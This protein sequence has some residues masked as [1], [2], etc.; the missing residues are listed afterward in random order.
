MMVAAVLIATVT[1]SAMI[2]PPGGLMAPTSTQTEGVNVTDKDNT[3]VTKP[4]DSFGGHSVMFVE[5]HGAAAITIMVLLYAAFTL[6]ICSLM[7]SLAALEV[8]NQ[9]T[10]MGFLCRARCCLS[11]WRATYMLANVTLVCAMLCVYGAFVAAASISF[12]AVGQ[13]TSPTGTWAACTAVSGF[14]VG[15]CAAWLMLG[16]FSVSRCVIRAWQKD[17]L[18][19]KK[20]DTFPEE[21]EGYGEADAEWNCCYCCYGSRQL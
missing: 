11:D 15:L 21:Q 8:P 12:N 7:L 19:V 1:F 4:P 16:P 6:S 13:S 18:P 14:A 20:L 9:R 10:N 3:T 17:T 2:L 5:G